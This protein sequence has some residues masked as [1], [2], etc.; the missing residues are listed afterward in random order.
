MRYFQVDA[1]ADQVF[2]GNPAGVCP[3]EGEWPGDELLQAVAA[4]NNLAET[5][6][7][8]PSRDIDGFD[9]RW[10]TPL[11]EVDLCGHATLAA[12]HVLFEELGNDRSSARFMTRSG[13]LR[14]SRGDPLQMQLPA[15]DG[16]EIEPAKAL[17]AALGVCPRVVLD[18]GYL[19]CELES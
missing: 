5:A 13:E 17:Q 10:F 4:E 14:V 6:F 2:E 7:F 18:A 19:V 15:F 9:L 16:S 1:F 8:R 11:A 12:A 3:L